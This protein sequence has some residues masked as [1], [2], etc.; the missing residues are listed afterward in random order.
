M[1]CKNDE[2]R[3][4]IDIGGHTLTIAEVIASPRPQIINKK[5]ISTPSPRTPKTLIDALVSLVREYVADGEKCCVG[6][7]VPGALDKTKRFCNLTNFGNVK[8]NLSELLTTELL[9]YNITAKVKAE[10]DANAVAVGEKVAGEANNLEDFVCVTLGTGVGGGI[11]SNNK[12]LTGAHGL[13]G[14]LGHIFLEDKARVCPCG[15]KGHLEAFVGAYVVEKEAT[16]L[17]VAYNFKELW[18]KRNTVEE[19]QKII[20][21]FLD[22]IA[23]AFATYIAILDPEVIFLYGGISKSD[24]IIPEITKRLTPL[25]STAEKQNC[26]IIVSGLGE[27]AALYGVALEQ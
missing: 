26:K 23:S 20:S 13:A 18:E 1:T 22:R 11:F 15:G 14:E 25:L 16:N 27:D 19:A 4:G 10:N 17:G 24:G 9:K 3:L 12:L 8:C 2:K 7:A 6:I 5:T 21:Q